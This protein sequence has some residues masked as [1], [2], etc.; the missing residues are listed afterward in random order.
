MRNNMKGPGV[1][2]NTGLRCYDQMGGGG[3][4]L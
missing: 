4:Y 2:I 1:E 3:T